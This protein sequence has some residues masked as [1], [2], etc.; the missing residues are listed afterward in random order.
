MHLAEGYAKHPDKFRVLVLCDLD[1]ERLAKVGAEFA[2]PRLTRSFDEVLAMRDIDIVDI[3]TPPALHVPQAMA[4]HTTDKDVV[5][6][7]PIASSLDEVDI[8]MAGER[9]ARDR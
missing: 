3:C 5:Y 9:T 1:E 6:E 7:K 8:L 2:V 4:A